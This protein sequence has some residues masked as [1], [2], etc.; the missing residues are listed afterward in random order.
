MDIRTLMCRGVR[1]SW[2]MT[3]LVMIMTVRVTKVHLNAQC[4]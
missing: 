3:H 1:G 2:M 4:C